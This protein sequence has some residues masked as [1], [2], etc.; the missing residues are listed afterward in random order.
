[1]FKPSY[2][3]GG[4]VL[5]GFCIFMGLVSV[6]YGSWVDEKLIRIVL[7]PGVLVLMFLFF[8][9]K[10]KLFLLLILVR[11]TIDP[12]IEATRLGPLSAG[13]L[14]NVLILLIALLLVMERPRAV[15]GIVF[16]MWLPLVLAMALAAVRAPD[17]GKG[18][19]VFLGYMTSIA[20]FIVPFYLKQCQ[21]DLGFTIRV[22][23]LSS[24]FPVFY[25]F[26]DYAQGGMGGVDGNRVSSVFPHANIF[27]FFLVVVITLAFYMAKTQVLKP[28]RTLRWALMAYIGFM[29][30][31]L[32]LTKTRSAWG[33]CAVVFVLYGLVFERK[34]LFY[35]AGAGLLALLI[36]DVRERLLELNAAKI[37]WSNNM[38]A[39]SFEWRRMIWESGLNYMK[40]SAYLLGYGSQSFAWYSIDFFPLANGGNWG[41]HNVYVQWFF[42]AGAVGILCAAW[43]YFRLF[44]ILKNGLRGDRLGSMMVITVVVEYLVVSFSDNMLDYLAFNWYFWFVLGTACAIITSQKADALTSAALAD[45]PKTVAPGLV[46]EHT[47]AAKRSTR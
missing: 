19:R 7:V 28:S 8:A 33:A 4:L 25:G 47:F 26:V 34:Y 31:D 16:P 2:L 42:E 30:V 35:I 21:K 38:P 14:M 40:P 37:Y 11:V 24:V 15:A 10:T 32:L 29:L 20:V 27:A 1:M 9:D 17:V 6:V 46:A 39:N 23:L 36:P 12:V 5:L 3:L 41:A 18:I 45:A 22:V 43:L 13:A 44:A